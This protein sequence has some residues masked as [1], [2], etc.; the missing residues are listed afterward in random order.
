MQKRLS[1][2]ESQIADMD[3]FIEKMSKEIDDFTDAVSSDIDDLGKDFFKKTK[4]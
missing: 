4:K 2:I 1:S 3:A